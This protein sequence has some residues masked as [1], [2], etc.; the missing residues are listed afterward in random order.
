MRLCSQRSWGLLGGP[1]VPG[2]GGGIAKVTGTEGEEEAAGK[3]HA[4]GGTRAESPLSL[5]LEQDDGLPEAQVLGLTGRQVGGG[6][7]VMGPS[8]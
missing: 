8:G 2:G 4:G 1:G 3:L 7:A 6:R 5:S